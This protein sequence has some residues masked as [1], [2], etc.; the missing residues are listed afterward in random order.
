[1]S[2]SRHPAVLVFEDEMNDISISRREFDKL[3]TQQRWRYIQGGG[4]ITDNETG[5]DTGTVTLADT[6]TRSRF[7]EMT[8]PERMSFIRSGGRVIDER[9]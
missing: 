8:A 2:T 9:K 7:D 6:I 4:Q 3:T 5:T 1:M